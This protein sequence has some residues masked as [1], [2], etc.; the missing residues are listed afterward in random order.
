MFELQGRAAFLVCWHTS[1][2]TLC[3]E[4]LAAEQEADVPWSGVQ[5]EH[6]L[7]R[8]YADKWMVRALGVGLFKRRLHR[9]EVEDTRQLLYTT[10]NPL[11]R[12]SA[13]PAF[14]SVFHMLQSTYIFWPACSCCCHS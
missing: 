10:I 9:K 13:L 7:A 12:V 1:R 2:T 8:K 4:V 11:A 14:P 5:D 3:C 6:I